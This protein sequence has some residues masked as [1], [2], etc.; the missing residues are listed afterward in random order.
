MLVQFEQAGFATLRDQWSAL[1]ALSG[2]PVQLKLGSETVPG[3]ARGVDVD[4]ALLLDV[5]G[6]VRRFVSGEASL[7]L[8]EDEL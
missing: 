5:D 7:R 3:I 8:I 1:D 2:R 6:S 4:G